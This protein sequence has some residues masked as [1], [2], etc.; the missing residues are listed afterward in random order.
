MFDGLREAI[1]GS[2]SR[3]TTILGVSAIVGSVAVF[4]Q[5]GELNIEA[6]TLAF[7]GLLG[8]VSRDGGNGSAA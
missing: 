2:G 1:L 4:L 6:I 5:G 7:M 3:K 8:L